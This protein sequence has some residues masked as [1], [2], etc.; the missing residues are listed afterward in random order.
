[1]RDGFKPAVRV[2]TA[3]SPIGRSPRG[4]CLLAVGD[5]GLTTVFL[6]DRSRLDAARRRVVR[7]APDQELVHC[8]IPVASFEGNG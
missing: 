5:I 4:G 1:M 6:F 3:R 7:G 2:K 8:H